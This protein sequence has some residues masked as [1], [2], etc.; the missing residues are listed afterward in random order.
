VDTINGARKYIRSESGIP[1]ATGDESRFSAGAPSAVVDRLSHV[2][3]AEPVDPNGAGSFWSA[4]RDRA[5]ARG[6]NLV[7]SAALQSSGPILQDLLE[8]ADR[9]SQRVGGPTDSSVFLVLR[10][11]WEG[12]LSFW[13]C[14]AADNL[15]RKKS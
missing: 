8:L 7:A 6:L 4:A 14:L 10:A 15:R 9:V 13:V 12:N 11:S 2:T 1:E 3:D 5:L